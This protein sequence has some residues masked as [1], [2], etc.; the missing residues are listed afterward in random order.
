MEKREKKEKRRKVEKRR[1]RRRKGEKRRNWRKYN[2]T[3]F[4]YIPF[5]IF[6]FFFTIDPSSFFPLPLLLSSPSPL[7]QNFLCSC[8][9]LFGG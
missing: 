5:L 6:F 9:F 8:L 7:W 4:A 3:S 1:G 2:P